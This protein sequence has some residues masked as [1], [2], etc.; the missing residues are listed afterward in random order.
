MILC[1]NII[2]NSIIKSNGWSSN[3]ENDSKQDFDFKCT[4]NENAW[5]RFLRYFT[6]LIL[7]KYKHIIFTWL[8]YI[9]NSSSVQW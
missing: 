2:Y 3:L 8:K 5:S 1:K 9:W 4:K 7:Y 6:L